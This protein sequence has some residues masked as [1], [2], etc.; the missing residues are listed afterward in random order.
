MT[1]YNKEVAED[2]KGR[3]VEGRDLTRAK[4]GNKNDR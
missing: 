4:V 2:E 1:L 3:V